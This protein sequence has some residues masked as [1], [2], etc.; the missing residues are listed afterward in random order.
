MHETL[1]IN[2]DWIGDIQTAFFDL[3]LML[4][5]YSHEKMY[6]S[7]HS[8]TCYRLATQRLLRRNGKSY[9]SEEHI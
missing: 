1:P 5:K 9:D 8:K 3:L 6:R 4:Q 7:K 2:G